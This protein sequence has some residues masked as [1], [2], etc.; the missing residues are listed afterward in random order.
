MKSFFYAFQI[1]AG[2]LKIQLVMFF[3]HWKEHIFLKEKKE[4]QFL[5]QLPPST[6]PPQICLSQ[7]KRERG[8]KQLDGASFSLPPPSLNR[9]DLHFYAWNTEVDWKHS[10]AIQTLKKRDPL[11]FIR[12]EDLQ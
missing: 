12:Y 10:V 1:R 6:S 2:L 4:N 8:G 9:P 7:R 5:F 3:S 11:S